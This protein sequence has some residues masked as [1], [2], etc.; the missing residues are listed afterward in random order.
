[1]YP[2]SLE[3]SGESSLLATTGVQYKT[4]VI[5]P[6]KYFPFTLYTGLLLLL[7]KQ[8]PFWNG[9]KTSCDREAIPC[10]LH[11]V[12]ITHPTL[13]LLKIHTHS[14]SLSVNWLLHAPA[15]TLAYVLSLKYSLSYILSHTNKWLC[16]SC[17]SNPKTHSTSLND[18]FRTGY[19]AP[20]KPAQVLPVTFIQE[21][22]WPNCQPHGKKPTKQESS[23]VLKILN[24]CSLIILVF[25]AKLFSFLKSW[26]S[27]NT[28]FYSPKSP[29]SKIYGNPGN[30]FLYLTLA[31]LV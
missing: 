7:T 11:G 25:R 9:Q 21:Y 8:I 24:T 1:M 31:A 23:R 16:D 30:S 17:P 5:T 6:P 29:K 12:G 22:Q 2:L 10:G 3:V 28:L 14:H 15:L 4:H 18:V 27:P 19:Q 13:V 26:R 20:G